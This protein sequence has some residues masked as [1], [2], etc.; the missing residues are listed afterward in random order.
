[1]CAG[2][3]CPEGKSITPRNCTY[4]EYCPEKSASPSPCPSSFYCANENLEWP[5]GRCRGGYLCKQR[6][7]THSPERVT[8]GKSCP[9]NSEGYPC[10][11]GYYCHGVSLVDSLA[12]LDEGEIRRDEAHGEKSAGAPTVS[13][14]LGLSFDRITE[15]LIVADYDNSRIIVLSLS[16]DSGKILAISLQDHNST[17]EV[18]TDMSMPLG[19]CLSS[20]GKKLYVAE[21]G[22]SKVS[23][24]DLETSQKED[25]K[26]TGD[27]MTH[28]ICAV[29][30]E[31][32][33]DIASSPDGDLYIV[34]TGTHKLLRV[35]EAEVEEVEILPPLLR[36]M[37]DKDLVYELG[38]ITS[39]AY[40]QLSSPTL[41]LTDAQKH[42]VWKLDLETNR[43]EQILG[44]GT[45]GFSGDGRIVPAPEAL[46]N[47]PA[48]VT[49]G[50]Q[51]CFTRG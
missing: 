18:A 32:P 40:G 24:I 4:G 26:I 14:L 12:T 7:T 50:E 51:A 21:A 30:L 2:Y 34:Q 44:T 39:V 6:A 10:P 43:L 19:L 11:I 25:L 28:V 47:K 22:G 5:T 41:F 48:A 37:K 36:T 1:M 49:L 29:R 16:T 20:D 15:Q 27:T 38:E 8:S 31:S 42:V 23:V 17:E 46:V 45:A 3:Y 9:E 13:G 35:S 33:R